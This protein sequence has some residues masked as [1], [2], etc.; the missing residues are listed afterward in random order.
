MRI[1]N[2]NRWSVGI[3][4]LCILMSLGCKPAKQ[5]R[6]FTF[7][8]TKKDIVEQ[9]DTKDSASPTCH[10][11]VHFSSLKQVGEKD[12]VA[13][14]INEILVNA[15]FNY[16]NLRPEEAVDSFIRSYVNN[17]RKDVLPFYL[18]NKE[19]E[20]GAAWF[21]YYYTLSTKGEQVN[22]TLYNYIANVELYE[23]G[24]HGSHN[25]F[26]FNFN[27][28][29]GKKLELED[30]FVPG[31]KPTLTK[32]LLKKLMEQQAV[33][34]LGELNEKGFLDFG[35]PMYP[36]KEF[37]LHKNTI[38]FLYNEYEIAPYALGK[39]ILQIPFR[40]LVQIMKK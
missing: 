39:T 9:V 21:E 35:T 3:T 16:K 25:T 12:T 28:N 6:D 8:E 24:A 19:K 40:D 18:E 1:K 32:I 14:N 15:L 33:K 11:S 34:T 22:D 2:K 37:L 20:D 27:L 36:S 5:V 10:L 17:Y 38:E 26:Y 7:L 23:G 13:S 30:I 4:T 29:T 31:Y